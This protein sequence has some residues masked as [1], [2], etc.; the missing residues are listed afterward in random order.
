MP[1]L[2][3]G[4][5]RTKCVGRVVSYKEKLLPS[6]ETHVR[7]FSGRAFLPVIGSFHDFIFNLD[8]FDIALIFR[9][10]DV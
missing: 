8:Y 5:W 9:A 2:C 4:R 3:K 6:L 10:V 7:I 1:S